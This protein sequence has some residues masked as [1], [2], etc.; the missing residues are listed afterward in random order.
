MLNPRMTSFAALAALF[1]LGAAASAQATVVPAPA[2]P[3][4]CAITAGVIAT[5]YDLDVSCEQ[6]PLR[7]VRIR[8]LDVIN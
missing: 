8:Q 1:W 7:R 6:I 4:A 2:A 3:T 5:C